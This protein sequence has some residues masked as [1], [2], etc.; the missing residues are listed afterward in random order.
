MCIEFMYNNAIFYFF[1]LYNFILY[2]SCILCIILL[3]LK[4]FYDIN[5]SIY[6]NI[7]YIY[8]IICKLYLSKFYRF[9]GM[10]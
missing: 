3:L 10:F 5:L 9:V 6:N 2:Y 4:H 7:E 8:K 1:N